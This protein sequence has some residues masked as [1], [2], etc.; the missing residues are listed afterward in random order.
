[1]NTHAGQKVHPN[2]LLA[3]LGA[4]AIAGGLAQL[5]IAPNLASIAEDFSVSL[6]TATLTLSVF[7]LAQAIAQAF[8]GPLADR[9]S[10]QSLLLFSLIVF[11]TSTVGIILTWSLGLLLILRVVQAVAATAG[12]VVSTVLAATW[13]GTKDR[14]RAMATIQ[15]GGSLGAAAAL[16]NGS[17]LGSFWGWRYAFVTPALVS[18]IGVFFLVT[19]ISKKATSSIKKSSRAEG[20]SDAS[21]LAVNP[22]TLTISAVSSS[23]YFGVFTF[24][25]LLPILY[26][27]R[28]AVP[29]W[30]IGF[31]MALLPLSVM[32]GS[33]VGGRFTPQDNKR[34][35]ILRSVVGATLGCAIVAISL[36]ISS[37]FLLASFFV[38]AELVLGFFIGLGTPGQLAL[39]VEHFPG[40]EGSVSSLFYLSRSLGMFAGPIV[41]AMLIDLSGFGSAFMVAALLNF[42]VYLASTKFVKDIYSSVQE[43]FG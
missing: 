23:Q 43:Q 32:I 19:I 13:F 4:A 33:W 1:M 36:G 28:T 24:Q 17:L 27:Q 8:Y 5:T 41:G 7:S 11:F 12:I 38:L 42:L 37:E 14:T 25:T 31:L 6:P 22:S 20:I 40:R 30:M 2:L 10:P 39:I 9:F 3:T 18:A 26:D 15:I 16:V 21:F 34:S 29:S 35:F